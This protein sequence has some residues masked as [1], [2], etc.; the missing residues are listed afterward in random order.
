MSSWFTKWFF[1]SFGVLAQV[2]VLTEEPW[3]V[4]AG[5]LMICIAVLI[6]MIRS[7]TDK[8][9]KD[10]A[11]Q[12]KEA[13]EHAKAERELFEKILE[14]KDQSHVAAMER[15]AAQCAAETDKHVERYDRLWAEF[16]KI[17]E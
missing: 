1:M 4:K 13:A 9:A 7:L 16:V 12:R 15:I 3:W 2:D 17:K 8:W 14:K 5:G 6:W 10:Q 11:S